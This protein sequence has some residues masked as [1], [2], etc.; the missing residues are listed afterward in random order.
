MR[1]SAGQSDA[2]VNAWLGW[3]AAIPMVAVLAQLPASMAVE[4][5]VSR[6]SLTVAGAMANALCW[7]VIILIPF[8]PLGAQGRMA[9]LAVTVAAVAVFGQIA[10]NARGS[11][12]GDLIPSRI[13]GGF[14]GRTTM[15][16]AVIATVFTL[17]EGGALDM[18]EY[19]PS[20]DI[21]AYGWLFGLGMVFGVASAALFWPQRD[22]RVTRPADEDGGAAP[23]P[24]RRFAAGLTA[25]LANRPLRWMAIFWTLWSMQ[26][27]AQPFYVAYL[28][29]D[30]SMPYL[31][32]ALL[33]MVATVSMLAFAPLWGRIV[34]RYGCRPV[35]TLCAAIIAPI[36]PAW[37]GMSRPAMVYALVPPLNLL[38][39]FA[40]A[41]VSV[42]GNTL[43][44]KLTPSVG[45]SVQ[46]ALY[47]VA[48]VVL[49]SPAPVIGGHLPAW[50]E[51][52]G[53]AA[54]LRYTFYCSSIFVWLALVAARRIPESG[55][56]PARRLLRDLPGEL[57]RHARITAVKLRSRLAGGGRG[58]VEGRARKPRRASGLTQPTGTAD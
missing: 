41:G 45:R 21:S 10:G 30:Q 56:L 4:A 29:R 27:M 12:L 55:I 6:R 9:T 57:R 23:T 17:F 43:V 31:H 5:G 52:L 40:A 42:A 19:S 13:R 11:W 33:Q 36:P 7:S 34:S 48:V 54:D 53:L 24:Y 35:L 1:L 25:T 32:M 26:A 8:L 3:L 15:F 22:V 46:L 18:V 16:G 44:Y 49:A 58:G 47:S 51:S 28:H 38:V 20:V 14:F 37:M 39:G 2:Q 50:L